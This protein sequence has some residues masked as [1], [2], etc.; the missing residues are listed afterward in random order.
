MDGSLGVIGHG[1]VLVVVPADP[2]VAGPGVG[3]VGRID[4]HPEEVEGAG[5]LG[6]LLRR[7]GRQARLL[8]ALQLAVE[9][10]L[11]ISD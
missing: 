10:H 9:I 3:Q 1:G 4:V 11:R 2:G 7:E 6:A 5:D 8:E